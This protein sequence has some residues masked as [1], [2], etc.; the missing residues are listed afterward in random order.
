MRFASCKV[1]ECNIFWEIEINSEMI[2]YI[3]CF[4]NAELEWNWRENFILNLNGPFDVNRKLEIDMKK[5][6]KSK[7]SAYI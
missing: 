7:S 4:K 6:T 3:S 1:A 2:D 5:L